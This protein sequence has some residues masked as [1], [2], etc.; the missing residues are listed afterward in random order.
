MADLDCPS[1]AKEVQEAVRSCKTVADARVIYATATL[2]VVS[3]P[4]ADIVECKREV[5]KMVRS[6]GEDLELDE[7]EMEELSARRSWFGQNRSKILMGISGFMLVAGLVTQYLMG[8]EARA[9]V[10]YIIAA[11]AGLA[12]V[13][14]MAVSALRRGKADMNVLMGIAVIGAL[15]IGFTGDPDVFCDAAIVIFLDQVGEWLEGWS[16]KKA[17]G[18]I[19]ALME[20]TPHVA[21]V[22]S[23]DGSTV[24]VQTSGVGCGYTIRVLPG[25]RVPLDGIVLAGESS[26]NE[27]PITG[28]SLPKDKAVG[29][30]VF[31][32]SLNTSAVV[33]VQVTAVEDD[34]TLARIVSQV[35]GAQAAKAP[36]EN[37]VDRFAAAYTPIVIA[38]AAVL[39]ILIPL[40]LTI[41]HGFDSEVWH[42]WVY[43]AC[44]LLVVACP[45]ALVI[46]TPVS[47]VSALSRA[48][49]S[50]ILV[51]GGAYFD[52][53]SRVTSVAFDKTGTLTEGAP[54]VTEVVAYGDATAD[55]VLAIAAALEGSSTHPLSRAVVEAAGE[56]GLAQRRATEVS[57]IAAQ[58][59]VGKVEGID[60]AV[61][62]LV[63][64]LERTTVPS[65]L[66]EVVERLGG[67]GASAIV[68][69]ANLTVVG[70]IAIADTL[71]DT[72]VSCVAA[73][74]QGR[75]PR[76]VEMLT[77]DNR[78]AA[79]AMADV[80]G[81]DR[82][83]AELIPAD[84]LGR[85]K[86]MQE[87]GE[88]VCMVG[89]GINDA[90]ALAQADLGVTMG[91]ASDTALEVA[92]VALLSSNLDQLPYF[93]SLAK[94]TMNVVRENIAFSITV[95]V[96]VFFLVVFGLAGM[97]AA[98]FADTG[99]AIIVVLNGMRLMKRSKLSI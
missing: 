67:T 99:V 47:F 46:S 30:E 15:I 54:H 76:T 50:G 61:G 91:Q 21:H 8:S 96:V 26:F 94:K 22:V 51:K 82:V 83:A 12:F 44:S 70:V 18:S 93:F 87:A 34:S 36:Y 1:C 63:F 19:E 10:F 60:C 92:D 85:I 89:D 69:C 49:N 98:V 58:G 55:D 7:A 24:D 97:S 68:V 23:P 72:A 16:M 17:R 4:D 71:R 37:F 79:R 77:G 5:L 45:C 42:Y 75:P 9:N 38:G 81:I 84:K 32:G 40:V 48:A 64:A 95:K 62:K 57:E 33:D 27:A 25:E 66:A 43:R 73:L 13:T 56:R 88:V 53:G 39:G 20:L 28:E 3:E 31:A 80:A 2:E 11:I 29:E 59:M 35:Q 78:H 65:D 41:Q 90:P 74:H 86:E 6:C 52:I 14:P